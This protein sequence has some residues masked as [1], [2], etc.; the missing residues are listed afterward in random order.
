MILCRSQAWHKILCHPAHGFEPSYQLKIK[1]YQVCN[2]GQ[3]VV[4][5]LVEPIPSIETL[6]N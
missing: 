6:K 3:I 2:Y 1:P 4:D 5:V